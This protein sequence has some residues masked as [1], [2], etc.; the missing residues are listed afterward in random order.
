ML[1]NSPSG[2]NQ[3]S[4]ATQAIAPQFLYLVGDLDLAT[5]EKLWFPEP[6]L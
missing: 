4:Y 3:I 5:I 1:V 6:K 2:S